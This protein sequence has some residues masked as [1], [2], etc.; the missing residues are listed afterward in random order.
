MIDYQ[1]KTLLVLPHL[2]DEFA[3]VPLIKKINQDSKK[4]LYIIYCAERNQSEELN[5]KRRKE[6]IKSLNILGCKIENIIYLNDIFKVDDLKL[7]ETSLN[8]YIFLLDFLKAENINQIITLNFEGGHPDH[9][10]LALIVRKISIINKN[11]HSFY[12]PAYNGGRSVV[13]PI[14]VFRPLKNQ[15]KYFH[16]ETFG[17]FAWF[18]AF[19]V[20]LQY[21]SERGAFIKLMPFIIFKAIFSKSIFISQKIN[22]ESVK[23][24]NSLS[25]RRYSVNIEDILTEIN[26][27]Q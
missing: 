24:R 13:F 22:I 3:L 18:D 4:E 21:K 26:S 25:L 8:I 7:H 19:L 11:I 23:W 20:A 16:K 5:K 17:F 14:S 1:K 9:D 2:D 10:S 15:D 6:S 27:I 12:V